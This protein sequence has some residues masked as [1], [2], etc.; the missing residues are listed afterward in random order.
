MTRNSDLR[1]YDLRYWW[2]NELDMDISAGLVRER[3]DSG[4]L[5]RQRRERSVSVVWK[6]RRFNLSIN[7]VSADEA[8]GAFERRRTSVLLQ[9]RRDL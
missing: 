2:R 9:A 6:R 5:P 4:L 7:L 8:Q 3:E 1:G